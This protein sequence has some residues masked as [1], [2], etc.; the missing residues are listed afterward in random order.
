MTTTFVDT[1]V[2]I[3]AHDPSAGAK[4]AEARRHLAGLWR[5]ST[6]ALSVQVL[7]E[8]YVNVTRKVARPAS[9]PA[10]R[11]IVRNYSRWPTYVADVSAV[12]EASEVAERHR[13]SFWDALIVVSARAMGAEVLLT[14]D[15]SHGQVIEGVRVEDPFRTEPA[16]PADTAVVNGGGRPPRS[17]R[18]RPRA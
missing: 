3:Y 17:A 8:M 15:L 1:N 14:E 16:E 13:M 7:A 9:A 6:G 18:R 12:L 10:A 4:H 5:D 11:R 2:L